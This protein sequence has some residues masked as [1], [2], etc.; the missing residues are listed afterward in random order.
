MES[1]PDGAGPNAQLGEDVRNFRSTPKYHVCHSSRRSNRR[2]RHSPAELLT[3]L[4]DALLVH[5]ALPAVYHSAL[6]D[7]MYLT[8]HESLAAVHEAVRLIQAT[9]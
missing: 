9:A 8:R 4:G 3:R 6:G 2:Y 5:R 7:E 1:G